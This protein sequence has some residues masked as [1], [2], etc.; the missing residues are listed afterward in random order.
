MAA[1]LDPATETG[2]SATGPKISIRLLYLKTELVLPIAALVKVLR[3]LK[4]V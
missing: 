4:L 1:S 3:A 2:Q